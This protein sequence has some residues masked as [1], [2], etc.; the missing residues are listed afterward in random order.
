VS[1]SPSVIYVP[2]NYATIR[3]AIKVANPGDTVFVYSGTYH[4]SIA[5]A[6]PVSLIGENRETTIIIG[7]GTGDVVYVSSDE[8][9]V[10]GFT[11]ENSGEEGTETAGDAG[12][13]L[14]GVKNCIVSNCS[15]T[16]NGFGIYI[17]S[18][19]NNVLENNIC[20]SNSNGG[21]LLWSSCNNNLIINNTSNSNGGFGGILLRDSCSSNTIANN[22]CELNARWDQHGIKLLYFC[23]N[24]VI[25]N[26]ICLNNGDGIFLRYSSN[27]LIINNTCNSNKR[28]GIQVHIGNYNNTIANNTCNWNTDAGIALYFSSDNNR[29]D[30]N[31]CSNNEHSGIFIWSC[32]NNTITNN[33]CYSNKRAGIEFENSSYNMVFYNIFSMNDGGVVFAGPPGWRMPDPEGEIMEMNLYGIRPYEKSVGNRISWN[34]VEKNRYNNDF[35]VE[36]DATHNWWG[37][38]SGPYHPT[39][40]PSGKGDSI[41]GNVLFKPWLEAPVG[42]RASDL[43]ISPSKVKI[44]EA[45]SISV[46]VTNTRGVAQTSTVTLRVNGT[47]E[48]TKEVTLSGGESALVTFEVAKDIAGTYYAEVNGLTGTFVVRSIVTAPQPAEEKTPSPLPWGSYMTIALVVI[49]AICIVVAIILHRR[50]ATIVKNKDQ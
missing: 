41:S 44:G 9:R 2:I 8:V 43:L 28:P 17:T 22:T 39:L 32:N 34:D 30:N 46:S 14:N 36:V 3:G 40:N 18:S 11:I 31:V 20:W 50:K 23:N 27:N 26:N 37:D 47:A 49:V 4:E 7:S 15:V 38:P 16:N 25:E 21:I 33:F 10:S 5:I 12:I 19:S 35:G 29:I 1:A 24:N 6:K 13:E 48:A 42:I 45:V